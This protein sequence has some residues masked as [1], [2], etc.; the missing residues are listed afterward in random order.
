MRLPKRA[1]SL[2]DVQFHFLD[3]IFL[4]RFLKCIVEFEV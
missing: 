3:Y 4:Q 1:N 2:V